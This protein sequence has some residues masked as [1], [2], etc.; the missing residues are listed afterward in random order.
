[1]DFGNVC[2]QQVPLAW[3]TGN[4]IDWDRKS[5]ALGLGMVSAAKLRVRCQ[6]FVTSKGIR[7][8]VESQGPPVSDQELWAAA[9]AWLKRAM[10]RLRAVEVTISVVRRKKRTLDILQ[11]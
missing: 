8:G 11:K 5:F 6:R 10:F 2:L 9:V 1:M 7:E 4:N 3:L